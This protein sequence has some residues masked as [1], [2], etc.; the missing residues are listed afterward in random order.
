MEEGAELFTLANVT[1]FGLAAEKQAHAL[2]HVGYGAFHLMEVK[3][4]AH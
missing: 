3:Y 1:F 4:T 2:H